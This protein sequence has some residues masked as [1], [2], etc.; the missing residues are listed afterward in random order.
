MYKFY[1]L[2]TFA[3]L[4]AG[5]IIYSCNQPAKGADNQAESRAVLLKHLE[6]VA[7]KNLTALEETLSP[8]GE[9]YLILP[10]SELSTTAKQ[11][12]SF[13][14]E[15]FQDTSWTFEPKIV[16]FEAGDQLAAATVEVMYREPDRNG[17]PYFNRMMVSY[18]LKNY[19][20][21]WYVIKDHACSIEKSD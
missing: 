12:L 4:F 17:K 10:N 19:G 14:E 11:F 5:I 7:G 9:M 6:A 15:W 3:L 18:V 8:E 2:T 1:W 21:K 16:L 20:G 13:H